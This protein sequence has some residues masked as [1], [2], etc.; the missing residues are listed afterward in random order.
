MRRTLSAAPDKKPAAV[1]D[2]YSPSAARN[3]GRPQDVVTG[4]IAPTT[5]SEP[6]AAGVQVSSKQANP[7]GPGSLAALF[8]S[9]GDA[10][11]PATPKPAE[12]WDTS[13]ANA[14]PTVQPAQAEPKR[15]RV[16]STG[17]VNVPAAAQAQP[18]HKAA[19]TPRQV[20]LQL[21]AHR[22]RDEAEAELAR[23][24]RDH[25]DIASA[26][27]SVDEEVFGGV[28][29]WRPHIAVVGDLHGLQGVC[30]RLRSEGIDCMV[31]AN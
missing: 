8:S 28:T 1:S 30:A 19:A 4:A 5:K 31:R 2:A 11:K 13:A 12:H 21:S 9:L 22:S 29:F 15:T 18:A 24:M 16:A 17:P 7:E 10:L 20:R 6:P 26:S 25:D 27:A 14:P 23:A 3:A